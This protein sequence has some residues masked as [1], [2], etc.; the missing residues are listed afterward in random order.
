[1]SK[2]PDGPYI[3]LV[4]E[5]YGVE[6][7][8][9]KLKLS[10]GGLSSLSQ[11]PQKC[12]YLV[13]PGLYFLKPTTVQKRPKAKSERMQPSV[14]MLETKLI[15]EEKLRKLYEIVTRAKHMT[16]QIDCIQQELTYLNSAVTR[17]RNTYC[18]AYMASEGK[19]TETMKHGDLKLAIFLPTL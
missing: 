8:S 3:I 10:C 16:L 1:L 15:S 6:I 2:F 18:R 17:Q 5:S 7:M 14:S 12:S 4:Y 11:N 9:W 19:G 13:I